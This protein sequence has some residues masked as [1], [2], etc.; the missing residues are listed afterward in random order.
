MDKLKKNMEI[1]TLT[2][3][4]TDKN[5]EVLKKCTQLQDEIKYLIKTINGGKSSEYGKDLMKIKFN[6]EV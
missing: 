4:S 5:T 3:S 6:S 1:N 2:F